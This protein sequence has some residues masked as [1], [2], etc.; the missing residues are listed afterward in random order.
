MTTADTRLTFEFKQ[1][2]EVAE[3]LLQGTYILPITA[4]E[5]SGVLF[6]R[7]G[8][9]RMGI[10]K[11]V[12]QFPDKYPHDCP[13][14]RFTSTIYHPQ[15]AADGFVDVHQPFKECNALRDNIAL[16][17][18]IY[19]KKI[20]FKIETSRAKNLEA[21]KSFREEPD[22]FTLMVKRCV[23][24]SHRSLYAS[25]ASL[26]FRRITDDSF[27]KTL[28]WLKTRKDVK[29]KVPTTPTATASGTGNSLVPPINLNAAASNEA[30]EEEDFMTWFQRGVAGIK[31]EPSSPSSPRS[32]RG[33]RGGLRK[34]N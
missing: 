11:F 16:A 2:Y 32:P 23:D 29:N 8:V 30:D 33:Q 3:V 17:L 28:S 22:K 27:E 13:T 12:M 31:M 34:A 18:L 25:D 7:S 9:Y 24:E 4:R 15:I 21:A 10:F 14:V 19:L 5:W 20:F 6:M 1:I 26:R